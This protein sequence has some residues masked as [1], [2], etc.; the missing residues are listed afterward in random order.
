[1]TGLA[2]IG[3]TDS[4]MLT[5]PPIQAAESFEELVHRF[6]AAKGEELGGNKPISVP[7]ENHSDDSRPR[8]QHGAD[9]NRDALD[10]GRLDVWR[11]APVILDAP[12][13]SMAWQEARARAES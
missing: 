7:H 10:F 9:Q 13:V 2:G 1:M 3:V 6:R 8:G 5:V 11:L 4:E 12:T